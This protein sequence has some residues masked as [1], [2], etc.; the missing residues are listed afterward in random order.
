MKKS[1]KIT[2]VM[3]HYVRDLKNS[4]FPKIKGLELSLFIE[5]IEYL[6]KHYRI[7][8]MEELIGAI[9]NNSE[10]PPRSVL[11]TFDDAYIDHYLHVFPILEKNKLQGSFFPP[12][13]AIT[14]HQVLDVNKIH[15]IL[16]SAENKQAIIA[17]IFKQLDIYRNDYN[18]QE[19]DFYFQKLA[20]ASRFD[21]KEVI[22]I[23]RLLQVELEEELRN[24][25][26]NYLFR[27]Y[28]SNDEP[29][30]SRELYMTLEQITCM[31]RNGMHIGNHGYDHC[32][33][34]SV[35][36]EKQEFEIDRSVEFIR[37]I[38]GNQSS[39]TMCYPYGSYN[40][41]TISILIR[42][43]CILGLTTQVGIANIKTDNRFELPRLDT[44]DIP[45]QRNAE[46]NDWFHKAE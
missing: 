41:D 3:Y 45:K 24:I 10:L 9:D 40:D 39:W 16:A 17:D 5:Q 20:I 4:R 29:A 36:K 32:W 42:K 25:I 8:T 35:P 27:K 14:E 21:T 12:V 23:K 43:G 31:K 34:A 22:F 37:E 19:K 26:T 7:I 18:L 11:L 15:Y 2:I 33:L 44:N 38:G 6:N 13:K 46:L 30:F 1:G 28:V